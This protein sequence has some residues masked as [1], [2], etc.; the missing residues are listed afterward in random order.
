PRPF[1]PGPAAGYP[2]P[3]P[4]HIA[5]PGPHPAGGAT[6]LL[7]YAAAPPPLLCHSST[8]RRASLAQGTMMAWRMLRRKDVHTG[9]VNLAFRLDHG[10]TKHFA[11]GTLGRLPQFVHGNGL[12]GAA[13]C[14][15]FK[16]ST[17]R[18]VNLL[19]YYSGGITTLVT[20]TYSTNYGTHSVH[21][22]EFEC[23]LTQG[24]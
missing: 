23:Y 3:K 9:L 12:Q 18:Y 10:G 20:S 21:Q 6:A 4:S 22:I 14:T 19:S 16:Q 17:I 2:D 13:N 15:V 7:G 11:T 8:G 5:L 24:I 1:L